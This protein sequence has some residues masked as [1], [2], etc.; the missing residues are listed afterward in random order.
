MNVAH[1]VRDGDFDAPKS[2][3]AAFQAAAKFVVSANASI[4]VEGAMAKGVKRGG[5]DD[6]GGGG[7]RDDDG[8]RGGGGGGGG[9]GADGPKRKRL[10]M[11]DG[12]RKWFEPKA[13]GN[14]DCPVECNSKKCKKKTVCVYSHVNK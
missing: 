1:A 2:I 12:A 8:G 13:G 5:R 14:D 10:K 11:E 7:G 3:G 9:G 4:R 6:D